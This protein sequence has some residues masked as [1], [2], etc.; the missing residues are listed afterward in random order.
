MLDGRLP[1]GEVGSSFGLQVIGVIPSHCGSAQVKKKI[2]VLD[3]DETLIHS[4][5]DGVLRPTVRPG[6]PPDF[7]LKVCGDG[8]IHLLLMS[9]HKLS[10]PVLRSGLGKTWHR[11]SQKEQSRWWHGGQV[12]VGAEDLL[13]FPCSSAG[14]HRQTS[15]PVFCT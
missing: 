11:I 6:T 8:E 13:I 1:E 10:F 9:R 7:I 2:L 3:L 14:G 4:H 5:H 12:C 15:C